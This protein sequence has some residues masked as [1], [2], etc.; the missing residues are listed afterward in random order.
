VTNEPETETTNGGGTDEGTAST[1]MSRESSTLE[2]TVG[3]TKTLSTVEPETSN[4]E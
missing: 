4:T 3:N 1:D 2:S